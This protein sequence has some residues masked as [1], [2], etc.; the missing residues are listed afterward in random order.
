[1]GNI[2]VS[3]EGWT[4]HWKDQ[5]KDKDKFQDKLMSWNETREWCQKHYTDI[6]MVHNENVTHFLKENVK[7]ISSPYYWIGM[8]KINGTWTWVANGQTMEYQN[9]A[10]NEPN[11]N[12]SNENC[13]ELYTS[14]TNNSGKWND[15]NCHLKKNPLCQKGKELEMKGGS[16]VQLVDPFS[17]RAHIFM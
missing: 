1:M 15:D 12:K 2:L 8:Q 3:V 6:V 14:S 11:N 5:D 17:V 13:V 10:L 9:W 16:L 7:N 4:Y